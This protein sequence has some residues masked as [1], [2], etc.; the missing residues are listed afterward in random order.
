ME[1]Q[2]HAPSPA[3]Y[4]IISVGPG[5]AGGGPAR[6]ITPGLCRWST[7]LPLHNS[8]APCIKKFNKKLAAGYPLMF[9]SR[10]VSE[11]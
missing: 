11:G 7:A 5:R 10:L 8:D 3:S 6:K 9:L 2:R 1:F 4:F